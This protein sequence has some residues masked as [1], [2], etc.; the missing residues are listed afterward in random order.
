MCPDWA[1]M[2]LLTGRYSSRAPFFPSK[3]GVPYR[4]KDRSIRFLTFDTC[5][6]PPRAVRTPRLFSAAASPR[7]R[8]PRTLAVNSIIGRTLVAIADYPLVEAI[9]QN[10]VKHPVLPD[11]ASRAKLNVRRSAKYFW[12][13]LWEMASV[14]ASLEPPLGSQKA[15]CRLPGTGGLSATP[16]RRQPG[17][18]PAGLSDRQLRRPATNPCSAGFACPAAALPRGPLRRRHRSGRRGDVHIPRVEQV[19]GWR[20]DH[21]VNDVGPPRHERHGL[22]WRPGVRA[23]AVVAGGVDATRLHRTRTGPY[24]TATRRDYHLD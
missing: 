22:S 8:E 24:A 15:T 23:A 13:S 12:P 4:A 10:V 17:L 14:I 5:H 6:L 9:S 18:R 20:R 11:A 21:H 19:P 3:K 2:A 1:P 7:S 16:H